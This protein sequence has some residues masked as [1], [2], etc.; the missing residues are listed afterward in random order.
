MYIGRTV[1]KIYWFKTVIPT[2]TL[3]S[4]LSPLLLKTMVF[5]FAVFNAF[6]FMKTSLNVIN[7]KSFALVANRLIGWCYKLA[8]YLHSLYYPLASLTFAP[9]YL[10]ICWRK[11]PVTTNLC[12]LWQWILIFTP[13]FCDVRITNRKFRLLYRYAQRSA[14]KPEAEFPLCETYTMC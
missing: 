1:S 7:F 2:A 8:K 5:D 10:N 9:S 3:P 13:T 12:K 11:L 14:I 4:L 6:L